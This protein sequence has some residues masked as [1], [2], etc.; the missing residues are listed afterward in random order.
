MLIQCT[1]DAAGPLSFATHSQTVY[2]LF[3]LITV[4]ILLVFCAKVTKHLQD[5]VHGVCKQCMS[6]NS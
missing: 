3:V 1:L 2:Q 4:T 5:H 6:R